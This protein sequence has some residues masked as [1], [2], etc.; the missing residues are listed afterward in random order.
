MSVGT[1]L[2]VARLATS[3]DEVERHH[4][5]DDFVV[6]S[7]TNIE[8]VKAAFGKAKIDH[9]IMGAGVELDDR[10]A[11]IREIFNSSDGT[12]V[13]MKDRESG[14]QGYLPFVLAIAGGIRE[15]SK[16]RVA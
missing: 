2:L 4:E 7:A 16:S 1:L 6:F 14:R 9:V 15:Y 3:N 12:S 11:I 5:L 8:E 13:H 10:L